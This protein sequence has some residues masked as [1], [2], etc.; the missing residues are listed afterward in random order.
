VDPKPILENSFVCLKG[1]RRE[2]ALQIEVCAYQPEW[3]QRRAVVRAL[4]GMG[5]KDTY[6]ILFKE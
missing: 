3:M 1:I 4:I 6:Q 2:E 5:V